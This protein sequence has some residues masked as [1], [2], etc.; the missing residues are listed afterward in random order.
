[1][2]P[3]YTMNIILFYFM[4]SSNWILLFGGFAQKKQ[5]VI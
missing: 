5:S 3:L 2:A 1:M 4:D